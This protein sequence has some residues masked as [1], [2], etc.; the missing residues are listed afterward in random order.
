MY[1]LR[2]FE[3]T[4]AKFNNQDQMHE[5]QAVDE[6]LQQ[7]VDARDTPMM[8]RMS[9]QA[10]ER[11]YREYLSGTTVKDL[12][13]AYG[14]MPQ[15]VKAIVYQKFLYWNEVYPRLGETHMRLSME[16]EYIY[17]SQHPFVDYGVDLE[18]MAIEEKGVQITRFTK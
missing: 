9:P 7:A 4:S 10:K 17:A 1:L 3:K 5:M 18:Q 16:M 13:L 8:G 6:A 15:R 12:S 11:L 2:S 14:V